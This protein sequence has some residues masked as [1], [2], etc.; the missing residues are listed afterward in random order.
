MRQQIIQE[1]ARSVVAAGGVENI[2]RSLVEAT[3]RGTGAKGCTLFALREQDGALTPHVS[4]GV[5]EVYL[6]RGQIIADHALRQ[7]LKG[8]SLFI[9]DANADPRIVRR[10]ELKREGISSIVFLPFRDRRGVRGLMR[11]Y[12]D[13]P[14]KFGREDLDFLNSV[15][16]LCGAILEMAEERELVIRDAEETRRTLVRMQDERRHFLSFLSMVAHDLKS[17]LVAVQGYLKMLLRKASDRLD[18]RLL[19]GIRRSIQRI[20]GMMEL[21]SDLLELSRLESGQVLAELKEV[22]WEEVLSAAVEMA[23]ELADPRGIHVASDIQHPLPKVFA[24]DIRLQQLIL[25]LVSNS[26]RFTPR[27]GRITIR[28]RRDDDRVVVSVED[29]GTGIEPQKLPHVFEEFFKGDPESPE[30]TGLGLSICKRIVDLHHGEIWAESPV[31]ETGRGTRV[32]FAIPVGVTCDL[33]DRW[34]LGETGAET[35]SLWRMGVR[36]SQGGDRV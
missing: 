18:E 31:P 1:I 9:W 25:N 27:G 34:K 10:E 5:G 35:P 6:Q 22:S 17:P 13:E 30:G 32:T 3:A 23:H 21:I 14:R 12:F 20:D 15:T 11:L 24:S 8:N 26:V 29:E 7:V 2:V 4:C 28:A 16:E 36:G 19:Q 33:R